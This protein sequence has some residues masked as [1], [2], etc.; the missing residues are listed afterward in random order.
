MSTNQRRFDIHGGI[1]TKISKRIFRFEDLHQVIY[2]SKVLSDDDKIPTWGHKVYYISFIF[3]EKKLFPITVMFP[4]QLT[5]QVLTMI[6][7]ME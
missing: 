3:K 5:G 2:W 6:R 4:S 7:A 1:D